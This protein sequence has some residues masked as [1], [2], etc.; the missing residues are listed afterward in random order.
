M[1]F[2]T[3]GIR[4]IVDRD[5]NTNLFYNIGK[6]FALFIRK[7]NLTKK[8]VIGC[9]TRLSSNTYMF[10]TI[11]GL[12]D[13]GI[14]VCIIDVVST[15]IISFLVSR[16]DYGGG[17][18]ITASHNDYRYN[19]IKIF[20]TMGEKATQE[21]ESFIEKYS[22]YR[23]K[24][25]YQKG[26][27]DYC[28]SLVE[29]YI[30]YLINYFNLDLSGLTIALDCANGSNYLIA[31]RIFKLLGGNVIECSCTPNGININ[32]KCGA[33]EIYNLKRE[34]KCHN[35]DIGIA[36]DG[37]G[38]RVRI[39]NKNGDIL[40]GDDL[41]YI[42]SSHLKNRCEL[43]NS[44]IVG[45]ILTNNGLDIALHNENIKIIKSDVGD[46]NVIQLMKKNNAVLGGE[47]SGHICFMNYL[48]SCDALF[49]SLYYLK[50][51][52]ENRDMCENVVKDICYLPSKTLNIPVSLMFRKMFDYDINFKNDIANITHKYCNTKIVVRPSGT[53]PVIRVYVE[54]ENE[55]QLNCALNDII[56][57]IKKQM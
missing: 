29:L 6:G 39:I 15:P 23:I 19:G 32:K 12:S 16:G 24:G 50:C 9:D 40:S 10:A 43:H 56:L 26:K 55:I 57:A 1:R 48:H 42:F 30:N 14:D 27:I 44:F 37:D 41:L 8:V 28:P 22:D 18:M 13:Y 34:M 31:P 38:D 35:V 49:N 54:G 33:N 3:D 25:V 52:T 7:Q 2:G 21:E 53:E 51:Y 5:I 36:Y 4:G 47:S 17:V 45:T 11:S 46:K 20:N